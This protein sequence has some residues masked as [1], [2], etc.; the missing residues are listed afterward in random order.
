MPL[1]S[2]PSDIKLDR[3]AVRRFGL[4]EFVRM[5]WHCVESAPFDD[6]WHIELICKHLEAVTRREIKRLIINIP[7]GCMKSL[8]VSVFWPVWEWIS[9]PERS[10]MYA[11]FDASL[12]RRDAVRAMELIEH[13]WFRARWPELAIG[14]GRKAT[15]A[16]EYYSNSGGLRFS[17]SVAGRSTGWH[18][19]TQVVDDPIKPKDTKGG[20][21]A[22]GVKLKEARDWWTGTMASRQKV[23]ETFARVIVMQRLHEEDLSGVCIA[24]GEYVLLRLPMEFEVDNAC[25]TKWGRDP[26][27]VEGELLW[28]S[29]YS[30]EKVKE[31][32][33]SV[34]GLG[35]ADYAA[36][37]QQRPM[38]K[39]G[40]IFKHSYFVKRYT[41]IP[42]DFQWLQS[43][44]MRFKESTTSGDMVVGGVWAY[45]NAQF[46]LVKVY[47][48]RWSFTETIAAMQLAIVEFPQAT[49]KLV[50]DKANGPAIVNILKTEIDGL[51]LVDPQGGKEA[52]ANAVSPLFEAGNVWLPD[53]SLMELWVDGYIEEMCAFPRGRFD[54]QVDMTSQALVRLKASALSRFINAMKAAKDQAN[55][56]K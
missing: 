18:G 3:E 24:S 54:D 33:D 22:T 10:W 15:S 25:V 12:S 36:Q 43:W 31:L 45:K 39:G 17:T 37:Y 19:D 34:K 47:R 56:Q 23:P 40:G 44:D 52:R 26:R 8:L 5:S 6:N 21:E 16:T 55:G 42:S 49:L 32:Q 53:E 51:V 7:P 1:D 38:P 2:A 11:S 13:P 9:H 28:P 27:T 48:G 20:S 35:A 14:Y 4:Y 50:E 46:Y 30:A 29:R 41:S